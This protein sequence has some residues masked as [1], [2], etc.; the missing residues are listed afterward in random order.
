MKWTIYVKDLG[1][2]VIPLTYDP[3]DSPSELYHMLVTQY[4]EWQHDRLLLLDTSQDDPYTLTHIADQ[5]VLTLIVLDAPFQERWSYMR[6]MTVA[7][8]ECYRALCYWDCK[9]WGD[10]YDDPFVTVT[11]CT[12]PLYILSTLDQKGFSVRTS[13]YSFATMIQWYPTLRAALESHQKYMNG[14]K[15]TEEDKEKGMTDDIVNRIIC[16]Y[17]KHFQA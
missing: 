5:T 9:L 7:D 2:N 13:D 1:G 6:R 3:A 8:Q 10:P 12:L 15:Q 16:L 11:H 14:K 4:E 17:Y